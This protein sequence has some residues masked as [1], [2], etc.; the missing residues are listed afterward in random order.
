MP[1]TTYDLILF[2]ESIFY[3]AVHRIRKV[4]DHYSKFLK[5]E[6]VI[7][8]RMHDREKYEKIV[9]LI[10]KHFNIIDQY[11]V[12]GSTG[13]I[14]VFTPILGNASWPTAKWW[15]RG[16]RWGSLIKKPF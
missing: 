12:P 15:M 8:V 10:V 14:L 11:N 9:E 4:L 16:L 1:A 13:I 7:V 6:G 2:R 3:I 5:N